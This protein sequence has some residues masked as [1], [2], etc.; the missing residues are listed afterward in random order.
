M[1]QTISLILIFQLSILQLTAQSKKILIKEYFQALAAQ[2]QFNGNILVA[3]QGKVLYQESFGYADFENKIRNKRNTAFTVASISKTLTATGILQ[4]AQEGKLRISD[5]VKKYLDWF[6]YEF[7]TLQHLLSHT[8]GLPPYNAFFDSLRISQPAKVFT[9]ADFSNGVTSHLKKLLYQPGERGNYDNINFIVLA[10]IIEQVSGLTYHDYI[11][12]HVL[13]PAKMSNTGFISLHQMYSGKT[14]LKVAHPY[15]YPHRYSDSLV[16]ASYVP[17]IVS[18]WSA[19]NFSGFGDYVST[20]DDLLKYDEALY[21]N[22]LLNTSIE[23]QAFTPVNL[24]DGKPNARNFGLGWQVWTDSSLGKV[25]YHSGNA[26]GLS[27]VIIRNISSHQTIIL[28]DNIHSNN[29]ESL[30]FEVLKILNGYAVPFPRKSIAAVFG[31]TLIDKGA[32]AARDTL[33]RLKQDTA[34]Y[35]LSE[36]ELNLLGY[37]FMGGSNNPNPYHFPEIHKYAEALETFRINTELYP[38]SWNVYDSYGEAL[39][40]AGRKKEAIEMYKKSVTLNPDNKGGI[41]VL[42]DLAE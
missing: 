11:S 16:R 25:V 7:I 35:Y 19:Y 14:T 33:F 39:L 26:T 2:G 31:K 40:V 37:D 42:N 24:N 27:C 15:L 5:P 36:D 10:L 12:T 17:Y 28:F 3:E 29:A 8:S 21:N 38:D 13:Q 20:V 6:P 41:K 1:R 32:N 18:Y 9:N 23:E 34:H 30:G 22:K 4:L